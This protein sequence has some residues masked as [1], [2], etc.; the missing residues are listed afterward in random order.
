MELLQ[1]GITAMLFSARLDLIAPVLLVERVALRGRVSWRLL[2][3]VWMGMGMGMA[4][5]WMEREQVGKHSIEN[6]HC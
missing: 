6:G 3:W 5:C 4:W 1:V 2:V